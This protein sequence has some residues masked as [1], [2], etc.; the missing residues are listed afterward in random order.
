MIGTVL[1]TRYELTGL[2]HDGSIFAAYSA[3]DRSNGRDV[4]VRV[5]KPPCSK[6]QPFLE[7]LSHVVARYRSIQSPGIEPLMDVDEDETSSYVVSELTRGPSLGERIRKLAPFSVPVSVGTSISICQALDAVHRAGLVHG[8]VSGQNIVIMANGD[9]RLQLTGVWE[10]YSSSPSAGAIVLPSMAPYM[11]PE[12]SSGSMPSAASDVYA[13]GI[14]L[15]ELLCG[16]PP[17]YADTPIATAMKHAAAP[18]PS[19]REINPSVPPV[20]DEIV[21]KAMAKDPAQR[22][23]NAGD[24]LS[25]LRLLQDALRFGK[26]LTWPLRTA[27]VPGPVPRTPAEP[28]PVAPRM[29]AIRP[30]EEEEPRQRTRADRDVPV[31]MMVSIAFL[32]A[33]VLSLLGVWLLFNLNKPKLVT[34][35]NIRGLTTAE[36]R[37]RLEPLKLSLRVASREADDTT[38]PDKILE[39]NPDPGQKVREGGRISVVVS[40]GSRFVAVPDLKGMTVDK[41]KSV[42]G[43]LDLG[44]DPVTDEA[45]DP[46]VPLGQVVRQAP[47]ARARV[48]RQSRVKLT[49][50][51]GPGE[52]TTRND[53]PPATADA[54]ESY[55]YT[56]SIRVTGTDRAT[57]VRV[58]ITDTEGTRTVYE[59]RHEPGEMAS[60]PPIKGFGPE[61][62]FRIY[63][64]DEMVKEFTK[65][66]TEGERTE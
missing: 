61:A 17:Y 55:L 10:A 42:L 24:L 50:S 6:E 49:V 29:S 66:A 57:D 25:D 21:K 41:A 8:D 64:D 15:Y 27:P 5:I 39:V 14:L 54:P 19:V 38:E 32:G 3:R 46:K 30:E 33:V 44:I 23:A 43:N 47:A 40:A 62:T 60:P 34:V 35:P 22:Y 26:S 12:V 58:E 13:V 18:T 1:G 37:Q 4:C 56:L 9:A 65:P 36:A 53:P 63:Y 28:Q 51:T 45:S 20:L 11:A 7:G 59:R 52:R 48:E 31:W 16:R 2:L